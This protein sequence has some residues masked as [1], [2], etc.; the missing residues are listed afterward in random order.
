MK[1]ENLSPA[2]QTRRNTAIV[3]VIALVTAI[4]GAFAGAILASMF[5]GI[6]GG[7]LGFEIKWWHG[8]LIGIVVGAVWGL[9][10]AVLIVRRSSAF[11][12]AVESLGMQPL[13]DV[14]TERISDDV[15]EI[16]IG[17]DV[18][19]WD[20]HFRMNEGV[21]IVLGDMGLQ[22][23]SN[24]DSSSPEKQ[25]TCAYFEFSDFVFPEFEL[26]PEGFGL[27]MLEAV[28]GRSDID[29]D[30]SPAF[31]DS[32]FLSGHP[33]ASIRQLFSP[34]VR[35]LF[36]QKPGFCVGAKGGRM[37]VYR[38]KESCR[39]NEL[40][41]FLSECLMIA[42][43]LQASGVDIPVEETRRPPETKE[44]A[45][46]KAEAMGGIVGAMLSRE[47]EKKAIRDD[48]ISDFLAQP[49]PRA[50]PTQ[51]RN[52]MKADPFL[53]VFGS[54]FSGFA[55]IFALA[56]LA[57]AEDR[58]D[59][60]LA[61]GI[62]FLIFVVGFSILF[63]VKFFERRRFRLLTHG[64]IREA[65][66]E[67]VKASSLVMGNERVFDVRLRLNDGANNR[68]MNTTVKGL[69][70]SKA[71][72]FSESGEAIRILQDPSEKSRLI[73]IDCHSIG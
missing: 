40:E 59:M 57:G 17:E 43:E 55:I 56:F 66:I 30:D 4:G 25:Q 19:F 41:S 35:K 26:K 33:E 34:T 7:W 68:T 20:C 44:T 70:V 18:R 14:D 24:S 38:L 15:S 61:I 16:I 45:L 31:S 65:V 47:I 29:F 36:E 12:K 2:A 73:L 60:W 11:S 46:E 9:I 71:K 6:V 22:R 10:Q 63:L 37:V 52:Q 48:E 69:A 28:V 23:R 49:V 64:D 21:K 72:E 50:I 39:I 42:G 62:S 67:S 1:S 32:Y 27:R 53:V 58:Q 8:I 3:L 54:L 13:S 51:L 5:G